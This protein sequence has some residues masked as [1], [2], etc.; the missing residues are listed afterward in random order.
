MPVTSNNEANLNS[1][2]NQKHNFIVL[3]L[4]LVQHY[5]APEQEKRIIQSDSP[6]NLSNEFSFFSFF[7]ANRGRN[8]I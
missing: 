8:V 5:A 1:T 3:S 2:K 7:P 4:F 6:N